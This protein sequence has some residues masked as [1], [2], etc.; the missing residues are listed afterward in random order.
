[1]PKGAALAVMPLHAKGHC[2]IPA[3]LGH[4]SHEVFGQATLTSANSTEFDLAPGFTDIVAYEFRGNSLDSTPPVISLVK[5]TIIDSSR[6]TITW[7]TN[8]ES[9]SKIQYSTDPSITS[10]DVFSGTFCNM[11]PLNPG[12]SRSCDGPV[13]VPASLSPGTFYLGAFV[14]DLQAVPEADEQNNARAA[15][16]G[17][18]TLTAAGAPALSLSLNQTVFAA[19]NV[20]SLTMTTQT[21][22]PTEVMVTVVCRELQNSQNTSPPN[23]QA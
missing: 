10:A 13:A 12:Q 20:L 8:E 15:D 23:R 3:E 14:D 22:V 9:T 2:K 6:V 4:G 19:G 1:M 5:S 21:G 17:P 7:T 11:P 16:T 18:I